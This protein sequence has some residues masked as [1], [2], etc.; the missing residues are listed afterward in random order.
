MVNSGRSGVSVL[1]L[2]SLWDQKH[3]R[4][5]EP[6]TKPQ[7]QQ[8]NEPL[9]PPPALPPKCKNRKLTGA[10]S[11][12]AVALTQVRRAPSLLTPLLNSSLTSHANVTQVGPKRSQ[13]PRGTT[14]W[15]QRKL[16]GLH[17]EGTEL[18][19]QR[20]EGKSRASRRLKSNTD[21]DESSSP[22]SSSPAPLKATG[23]LLDPEWSS[24]ASNPQNQFRTNPLYH[25]SERSEVGSTQQGSVTY[26]EVLQRPISTRRSEK[27][28]KL[29]PKEPDQGNTYESVEEMK[30]KKSTWGKNVSKRRRT[31]LQT[32]SGSWNR[33]FFSL[34][35]I[36]WRHFLPDSKKK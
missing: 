7:S 4:P 31:S 12:D 3:G 33:S 29:M 32:P 26:S 2:R 34:Q 20:E 6:A 22:P 35:N 21:E 24:S 16:G 36:K 28:C 15:D 14:N 5:I 10:V 17:P 30:T 11:I 1:A 27:T 25:T 8:L 19:E 13:S 9:L 18:S 23:S